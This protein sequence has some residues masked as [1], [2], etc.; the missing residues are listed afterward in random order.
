MR[1]RSFFP[2]EFVDLVYL[3]PPFNSDR[4]YNVLF[5]NRAGAESDA[6]IVAFDDTWTWS[7]D[8][9]HLLKQLKT[10]APT[11]VV[12][13]LTGFQKLLGPSD[14]LSYLVMMAARLIEIH[15]VMKPTGS[16]Y[17]H[18]DPVASHYLKVLS[19]G[20]FGVTNF[21]N[22]I[23]W[24]R[25]GAK[26]SPM[27]RLPSN[28]DIILFYGKSSN[29]TWNPPIDSYNLADLDKKTNEKYS[30]SD[31][32]GR[33]Y[34]LT[35]LLH[36][37]QGRRPNLEYELMG[38][39]RTWRWSKDRMDEAV[40]AG[41][42]VQTSPGNVPRQK[43]YLD[44]QKGRLISDVWADI[45]PL[46][47]QAKER[48]GYPTQ[49]PLA[50]LERIIKASSN[51][52]DIVLDP[53]CGCGTAVDAAQ[54]LGR[55]WIGID[56][57]Y[58]AI[59]L[60]EHRLE[61]TYGHEVRSTFE[62]V[63][64][65]RDAAGA[66]ALFDRN[67]FDFER[68]AV[69]LVDGHPNARQVGDKGSDG[70]IRFWRS[71]DD[72][73]EV[74]VSVKGGGQINPSMVRDLRGTVERRGSEL[75]LL[76]LLT[77]PTKGMVEEANH[78]GSYTHPMTGQTYPR[79]QLTTIDQLLAGIKPKLPTPVNPYFEPERWDDQGEQLTLPT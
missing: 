54:R 28:H 15:R 12:D 34:Q 32:D 49:K 70:Q 56:V 13:T 78:S 65:P 55:Q 39:T 7:Q 21:R 29:V 72:L 57:T 63:G 52:G 68:W 59:D 20:L 67:P 45:S 77:P 53:F 3:D 18:C 27:G 46:N 73:G 44:E 40:A 4:T 33:R 23:T 6:Q 50:L 16:I 62:I 19:D 36:P 79:I 17:L 47:S 64:I 42:V 24:Q 48:L 8:D 35:S 30:F 2:D 14:M 11:P 61:K 5:K 25:T 38:V 51:P 41:L 1:D 37:E 60:I 66:N 74:T 10:T 69:S 22:E 58:L 71:R 76:I 9:E 43:R 75:G 31:P 26:G